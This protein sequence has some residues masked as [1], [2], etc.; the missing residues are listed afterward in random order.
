MTPGLS[1]TTRH[2]RALAASRIA[3][4]ACAFEISGTKTLGMTGDEKARQSAPGE[5]ERAKWRRCG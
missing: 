2:L 1:S 3:S 5:G 4:L